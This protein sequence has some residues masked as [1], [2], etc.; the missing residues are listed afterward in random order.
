MTLIEPYV[1]NLSFMRLFP[2]IRDTVRMRN[3]L[4]RPRTHMV[5]GVQTIVNLAECLVKMGLNC[6]FRFSST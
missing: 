2:Q 5:H 1:C 3:V 6:S 4:S